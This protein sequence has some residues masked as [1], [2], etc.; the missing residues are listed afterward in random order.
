MSTSTR[1]WLYG[2]PTPAPPPAAVRDDR[3]HVWAHESDD[4]Y[5]TLDGRHRTR[6]AEL[7]AHTDL[8]EVPLPRAP[9]TSSI[10]RSSHASSG[11]RPPIDTCAAPGC[12]TPTAGVFCLPCATR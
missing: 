4:L 6:W 11:Y 10:E 3:F 9:Q 8:V 1:V 5:A 12:T 7:A 2:S